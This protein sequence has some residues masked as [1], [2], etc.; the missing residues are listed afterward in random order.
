MDMLTGGFTKGLSGSLGFIKPSQFN[1]FQEGDLCPEFSQYGI[2][3]ILLATGNSE[4]NPQ[5][6]ITARLTHIHTHAGVA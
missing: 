5:E 2:V 4:T 6:K 1:P 3:C